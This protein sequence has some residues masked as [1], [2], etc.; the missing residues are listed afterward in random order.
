CIVRAIT[1]LRD[2]NTFEVHIDATT[3][4]V[5]YDTATGTATF[6]AT[7]P[8]YSGSYTW[9]VD[10]SADDL[11]DNGAYPTRKTT[12]GLEAGDDYVSFA[13]VGLP[14]SENK[15]TFR[16]TSPDAAI[17]ANTRVTPINCDPTDNGII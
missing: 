13:H 5:C 7:D 1:E 9:A 15:K 3:D 17:I 16:I 6:S 10:T 14:T 11:V 12:I 4:V 8:T 2:P